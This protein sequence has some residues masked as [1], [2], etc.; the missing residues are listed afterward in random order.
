M[1]REHAPRFSIITFPED[2]LQKRLAAGNVALR[3]SLLH[4]L[5][6]SRDV[7]KRS[8]LRSVLEQWAGGYGAGPF[9]DTLRAHLLLAGDTAE[10]VRGLLDP[11]VT[12]LTSERLALILPF[13][14]DPGAAFD[15]GI[16]IS[17]FYENV[18]QRLAE[19]PP[20]VVQPAYRQMCTP[21]ACAA[22]ASLHSAKGDARMRHVGLMAAFALD[23]LRWVDSVRADTVRAR[24]RN[25]SGGIGATWPASSHPHMPPK[26]ASWRAWAEWMNG[27]APSDSII[28]GGVVAPEFRFEESHANA[29]AFYEILSGRNITAEW[30]DDADHAT[31]ALEHYVFERMLAGR[32][33]WHPSPDS[34]ALWLTGL[35]TIGQARGALGAQVVME[36]APAPDSAAATALINRVLAHVI[37]GELPW[38]RIGSASAPMPTGSLLDNATRPYK[39]LAGQEPQ[40]IF[41]KSAIVTAELRAKWGSRVTWIT[42]PKWR[43]SEDSYPATVVTIY[44]LAARDV[45][46]SINAD[47]FSARKGRRGIDAGNGGNGYLLLR[48]PQGWRIISVSSWMA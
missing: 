13:A 2:S 8:Q 3:D 7:E 16:P 29:A 28:A 30:R 9:A 32:N 27:E 44:G 41:V 15:W 46:A 25:L 6:R 1:A 37:D 36:G 35:S 12:K 40:T 34:V 47:V 5:D 22:L 10:V 48:T 21:V 24:I 14:R 23:P 45:F 33:A 26:G 19:Y 38:P 31:S 39:G 43:L 18:E 42:D 20:A 11:A 4:E 17:Q